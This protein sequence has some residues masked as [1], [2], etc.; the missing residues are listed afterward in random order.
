MLHAVNRR[1]ARL[2]V[3]RGPGR[4]IPLE[5]VVTSTVF[6]PLLFL[7]P[8]EAERAVSLILRTL[9][10]QPPAWVGPAHLSLWP[11]RPTVEALRSNYIEPDAEIA[12]ASGNTL[13]IEVK[14]GRDL[15]LHELAAQWLS[16]SPAVRERS[17]HVLLVLERARYE[18]SIT[19]DGGIIARACS[20][21]WPIHLVTWRRLADAFRVVGGDASLNAGTRRW[22]RG[23]HGF[24]KREDPLTLVG[25][26]ETGVAPVDKSTWRFSDRWRSEAYQVAPHVA[27]WLIGQVSAALG[28]PA[29]PPKGTR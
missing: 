12:D 11:K 28:D 17:R 14:W 20:L 6:G 22:A 10:I 9:G 24:L 19:A 26:D 29:K 2:E 3:F 7:D 4:R 8:A 13:M 18:A 1:K 5:D 15:S 21:P 23:V 16:L 27:T 25:W